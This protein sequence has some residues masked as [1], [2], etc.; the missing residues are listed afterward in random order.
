MAEIKIDGNDI[1][2]CG[3]GQGERCCVFL[4]LDEK[5]FCCMRDTEMGGFLFSRNMGARRAPIVPY[6]ECQLK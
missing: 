1:K 4:V 6:P 2:K 5:S 3:A